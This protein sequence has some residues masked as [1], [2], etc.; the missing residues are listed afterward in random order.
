MDTAR[1]GQGAAEAN[2]SGDDAIDPGQGGGR[3]L[4]QRHP[5]RLRDT[6]AGAARGIIG[7][8]LRQE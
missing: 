4:G 2:A 7:P 3:G 6:G 1:I 8:G 5:H